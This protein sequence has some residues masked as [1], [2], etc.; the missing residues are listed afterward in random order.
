[1]TVAN[2]LKLKGD[3]DV[4]TILSTA[5]I[6]D[7]LALLADKGIG[8][9]VVSAD[10][11]RVDGILSER[12]IVRA[13]ARSGS[14]VLDMHVADLMTANVQTTSRTED[15]DMVLARMTKGRFR[16]MPVVEDGRLVGIITIGDVVKQRLTEVAMEKEALQGMIM[17]Y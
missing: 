4:V 12:D 10:G 3:S 16:H 7:A 6:P 13:L 15:S 2:I 9:V 14:T 17:G 5:T 1:M 11:E 8:T